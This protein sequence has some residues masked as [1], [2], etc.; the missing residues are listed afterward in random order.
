LDKAR[1]TQL[2]S[3]PHSTR[4]SGVRARVARAA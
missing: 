1:L 4:A 2:F 3:H